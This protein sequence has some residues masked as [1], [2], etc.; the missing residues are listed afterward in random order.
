LFNTIYSAPFNNLTM[1]NSSLI[2]THCHLDF[3]VFDDDRQQVLQRALKNNI[4]DIIIPGTQRIYWQRIKQL[5]DNNKHLHPCYGLHPYWLYR[6]QQSDIKQLAD[7]IGNNPALAVGE[8]GLDFRPQRVDKNIQLDFLQ[9]QFDI[10]CNAELPVV[11]HAVNATEAVIQSIK[12]FNGLNGMIHSYSGSSEQARQLIDL[13]FLISVSGSIT[14]DNA[15]KIKQVVKAIPMI[16]LLA[17]TDAPDQSDQSHLGK[18]N[19]PAYL[20][21]TIA[22]IA[23]LKQLPID[24]VAQQTTTNAK[25]L[26]RI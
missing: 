26:F 24:T 21:N 22:A 15:K 2:D 1:S 18:R 7:F 23:E 19:E 14:F 20:V 5:C 9:A 4:Q 11:I 3:E 13:G 8:C 12:K 25:K 10:A 16:S 6:H 17:E